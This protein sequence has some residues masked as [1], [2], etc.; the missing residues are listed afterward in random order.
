MV[1]K[2]IIIVYL[3]LGVTYN[4]YAHDSERLEQLEQ[5][6]QETKER[7]SELESTLK[8]TS[9]DKA[10]VK[11]NDGWKYVSN[12]RML[13]Q[14]MSYDDVRNILGE[15]QRIRGG[16]VATWYYKN[17]SEVTFLSNSLHSWQE[18]R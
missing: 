6:L 2:I 4:S 11:T 12:W 17:K 5:D 9:K 7:L 1:K 8:N 15:P 10:V 16:S 3:S 13:K 14:G 18:P